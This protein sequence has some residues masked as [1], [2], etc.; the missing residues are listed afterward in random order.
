MTKTINIILLHLCVIFIASCDTQPS[1]SNHQDLVDFFNDKGKYPRFTNSSLNFGDTIDLSIKN[2]LQF[3]LGRFNDKIYRKAAYQFVDDQESI[4]YFMYGL[5]K[6][7][8]TL[9][10]VRIRSFKYDSLIGDFLLID[11]YKNKSL[12]YDYLYDDYQ[13]D[14]PTLVV[15]AMNSLKETH[16]SFYSFYQGRIINNTIVPDTIF[17]RH[18]LLS[19]TGQKIMI[20]DDFDSKTLTIGNEKTIVTGSIKRL[21][22]GEDCEKHLIVQ[23][24]KKLLGFSYL[25]LDEKISDMSSLYGLET[26]SLIEGREACLKV[27]GKPFSERKLI[28]EE[29]VYI[30][31]K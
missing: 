26:D 17:R 21:F 10:E 13:Y 29:V 30:D 1:L 25:Y 14:E 28:Q 4:S 24:N 6:E 18:D 22:R 7:E 11:L 19:K 12:N 23:L 20:Y 16:Y 3:N 5:S 8:F 2:L 15:K 9:D 31:Y 27:S